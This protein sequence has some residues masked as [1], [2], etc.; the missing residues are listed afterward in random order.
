[1]SI[2]PAS[3]VVPPSSEAGQS[4]LVV[5][6]DPT[7]LSMIDLLL[8]HYEYAPQLAPT[9]A[10]AR[11]LLAAGDPDVIV[12]DLNLPDG[13]GVDLLE[14][15]RST[16]RRA[17]VIVLTAG[18]APEHLRRLRSLRPD[19]LFVKP[20][21]FLELLAGIRAEIADAANGVAGQAAAAGN[22]TMA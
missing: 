16:G 8:R 12:L 3:S 2:L 18:S 17:R 5:E 20:M 22:A 15:L 14:H 9:L 19:R 11:R 21:N 13:N 7:L 4:V 1:M 6:D 10:E